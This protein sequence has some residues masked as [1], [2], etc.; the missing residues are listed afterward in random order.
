VVDQE[1]LLFAPEAKALF[2]AGI[3]SPRLNAKMVVN[4][5]SWGR[6]WIGDETLFSGVRLLPPG[7]VLQW[8]GNNLRVLR[9]WDLRFD[10]EKEIDDGFV[11][12]LVD[13]FRRSVSDFTFDG[14]RYGLSL[15]GG[16]DS[17][18]VLAA[19]EPTRRAAMHTYTWGVGEDNAELSIAR[20][21]AEELNVPW[22]FL[23]LAPADFLQHAE[24]GIALSDGLDMFV[25]SYGLL[26]YPRIAS[27]TDILLTGIALDVTLGGSYLTPGLVDGS[28]KGQDA[29]AAALHKAEYFAPEMTRQ[30]VRL[31]NV[32]ELMEELRADAS[33]V[34]EGGESEHPADRSDRFFLLTRVWRN[35]FYRQLWQRLFLEDVAPTFHNGFIDALLRIPP[36][37]RA[38]HRVYQRFLQHLHPGVCRIPYQRTTVPPSA[39]LEYWERGARLEAERESLYRD[40]WRASGEKVFIPYRRYYTNFDEWL[41][42]EPAWT[43]FADSMLR[44]DNSRIYAGLV[45]KSSVH[46]LLDEHRSGARSRHQQIVQIL[47]L[48]LFLRTYFP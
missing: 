2:S 26:V 34:W 20:A 8:D 15:S 13:L 45:D 5:L 19:V 18:S 47:T 41:R 17:R 28:L 40:I 7:S 3:L 27:G 25:Q 36:A 44:R 9:Y 30:L 31:P 1:T 12:N 37:W 16:L 22:T 29:F 39:P 4:Q 6:I 46:R 10:P 23:P 38:G 33:A 35:L 24:R 32:D 14:L 42:L 43:A 21:T 48:E 11:A